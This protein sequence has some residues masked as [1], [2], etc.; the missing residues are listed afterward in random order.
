MTFGLRENKLLLTNKLYVVL[1][2]KK[3]KKK[4]Y[5]VLPYVIY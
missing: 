4:L 1:T 2:S 5:V 3:N